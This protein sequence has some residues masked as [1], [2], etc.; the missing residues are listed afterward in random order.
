VVIATGAVVS[1]DVA[2]YTIVGGVPVST[3]R[4]RFSPHIGARLP[5]IAWW[6]WL[7][8][9]IIERLPDFQDDNI[10]AFCEKWGNS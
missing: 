8:Q 5:Q 1:K 7:L 9:T 3:I 10:V 6:A 2:S 4:L